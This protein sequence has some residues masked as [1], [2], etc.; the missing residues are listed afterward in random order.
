MKFFVQP[1]TAGSQAA[2]DTITANF[3]QKRVVMA[4][5]SLPFG[6]IDSNGPSAT[7]MMTSTI[8]VNFVE[9]H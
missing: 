2:G 5:I 4:R 1:V 8:K 7:I 6:P 3:S 9:L